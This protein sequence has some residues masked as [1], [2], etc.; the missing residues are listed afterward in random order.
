MLYQLSYNGFYPEAWIR[1][2]DHSIV[3]RSCLLQGAFTN[4]SSCF[5]EVNV[6]L[7]SR[8][9]LAMQSRIG[10]LNLC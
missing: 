2:K 9:Q 6:E 1:T 4:L 7:L 3:S 8:N 5:R 10:D